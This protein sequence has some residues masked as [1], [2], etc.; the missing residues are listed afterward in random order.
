MPFLKTVFFV[1]YF[2]ILGLLSVYGVHRWYLVWMFYKNSNQKPLPVS[3]FSE[4]PVITIQLPIYN[5]LYV[6][7]RL[8]D[9]VS[10]IKYPKDK[11]EIQVLDDSTDE[12]AL[13]AEKEVER[14]KKQGF[15]AVYIHRT[16]RNGFKAGAL[17]AGLKTARGEFLMI[18]DAD[19]MPGED[20]IAKTIDYFT[21][22]KVGM[23]Q[24]QV[25]TC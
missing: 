11:L 4:P 16:N 17:D 8:L 12:T 6:V 19:F 1:F 21:D 22:P 18:F 7:K 9:C 10:K 14:L 5:E 24:F 13:S 3:K 23:V 15:D 2:I 20:V 25:G